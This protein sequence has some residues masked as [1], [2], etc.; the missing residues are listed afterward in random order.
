M[1]NILIVLLVFAFGFIGVSASAQK[2]KKRPPKQENV[3]TQEDGNAKVDESKRQKE[4]EYKASKEHHKRIQDKSTL[5]RMKKNY[6]HAQKHSIG[7]D[8]PFYK[9]WFHRK[10]I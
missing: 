4:E 1:K 3:V 9:R 6:K 10:K 2:Q 5:K 8:V 7:R